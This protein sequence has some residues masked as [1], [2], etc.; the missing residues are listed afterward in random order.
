MLGSA[1]ENQSIANTT[2]LARAA[3]A[4]VPLTSLAV[5]TDTP[6][7][8]LQDAVPVV[9]IQ[10]A[11]LKPVQDP[12]I[13]VV[14]IHN[15]HAQSSVIAEKSHNEIPRTVISHDCTNTPIQEKFASSVS[16]VAL[17]RS[18]AQRAAKSTTEAK[19]DVE[20]DVHL[21]RPTNETNLKDS[22][23]QR[24]LVSDHSDCSSYVPYPNKMI[25][26]YKSYVPQRSPMSACE[27]IFRVPNYTFSSVPPYSANATDKRSQMQHSWV[28]F[29][30]KSI[31]NATSS[32]ID[33]LNMKDDSDVEDDDADHESVHSGKSYNG[34]MM[35]EGVV[36]HTDTPP[37]SSGLNKNDIRKDKACVDAQG[38][39]SKVV[40]CVDIQGTS[41]QTTAAECD[42]SIEGTH[43]YR[44]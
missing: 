21:A 32:I 4:A 38:V 2:P 8:T 17:D 34:T 39:Q 20:V 36:V 29:A 31:I 12:Q 28:S 43:R 22:G 42:F 37:S 5:P 18:A 33:L 10:N 1:S 23:P 27:P 16:N 40:R 9:K 6:E 15:D 24:S 25:S 13:I 7:D 35:V 44:R 11:D 3:S 14:Q 30:R 26:D 41:P 19:S